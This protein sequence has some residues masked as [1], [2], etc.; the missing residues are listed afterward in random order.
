MKS[1]YREYWITWMDQRTYAVSLRR[2]NENIALMVA[3]LRVCSILINWIADYLLARRRMLRSC[4]SQTE[5]LIPPCQLKPCPSETW[6]MTRLHHFTRTRGA[7]PTSVF[8][9][10]PHKSKE[11]KESNYILDFSLPCV[12]LHPTRLVCRLCTFTSDLTIPFT[13]LFLIYAKLEGDS[14]W[15][16]TLCSTA[17]IQTK[18]C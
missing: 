9:N 7:E 16:S 4:K 13:S 10:F 17:S 1:A 2:A 15:Y 12:I 3:A 5:R 11:F 6:C 8:T 14:N 18:I